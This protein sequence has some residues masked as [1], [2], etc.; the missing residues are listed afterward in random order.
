[1]DPANRREA[2]RE[3]ELD[4]LEGADYLM[5]KPALHYMDIISDL[6][7]TS[8]LPIVCYHVSGECAMLLAAA[9]KGWLDYETA[10]PETLLSLRRAGADVI[11]TYFAKDYAAWYRNQ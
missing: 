10:M 9:E 2:L 11:I 1:M 3:A 7:E 6:K 4:A 8:H 5:V